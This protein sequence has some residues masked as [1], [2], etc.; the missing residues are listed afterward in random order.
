[1]SRPSRTQFSGEREP[2]LQPST[3]CEPVDN[4][5]PTTEES[6]Q[7]INQYSTTDLC[8]ILGGL[9]SAVFLG[10]LDGWSHTSIKFFSRS[11][12]VGTIVATLLTP[13]GS[14]F[15]K[16]NQSSYIGTAYLLSVCCFTPLYGTSKH[17]AVSAEF[18]FYEI[19]AVC[20][21]SSAEK[22]QCFLL[23][24]YSVRFRGHNTQSNT[25]IFPGTGTILC[26]LA[27]SME[28]LITARAIAGMGGGGYVGIELL[29]NVMLIRLFKPIIS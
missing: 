11:N 10:A 13:I 14:Y 5:G 15:N 21:T 29:L 16:F 25:N 2:L 7:L 20:P 6:S 12:L 18:D 1:M 28:A 26:G 3:T 22:V 19:K 8:W 17:F 23:W 24:A 4:E 9:W 27:T